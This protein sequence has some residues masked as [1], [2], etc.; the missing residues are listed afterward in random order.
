MF[1]E[2]G[3]L[4]GVVVRGGWEVVEGVT[5]VLWGVGGWQVCPCIGGDQLEEGLTERPKIRLSSTVARDQ[6][7]CLP[8]RMCPILLPRAVHH[9]GEPDQQDEKA[10]PMFT[11]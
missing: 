5:G 3:S 2:G 8:E 7:L 11:G 1:L 6:W 10:A 9:S 4:E